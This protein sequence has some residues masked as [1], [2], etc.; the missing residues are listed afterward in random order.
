VVAEIQYCDL[1]IRGRPPPDD[2]I[3]LQALPQAYWTNEKNKLRDKENKLRDEKNKLL[4]KENVLQ[5]KSELLLKNYYITNWK[6]AEVHEITYKGNFGVFLFQLGVGFHVGAGK[7]LYALMPGAAQEEKIR[8]TNKAELEDILKFID[9]KSE[10]VEE[11]SQV[12]FVYP[13][14]ETPENSPVKTFV[15]PINEAVRNDVISTS[16]GSSQTG[17]AKTDR[18]TYQRRFAARLATRDET[19]RLCGGDKALQGAHIVDAEV[20]LTIDEMKALDL[21]H[22]YDLWNGILLCAVCH[23]QYDHWKLGID[24]DGFL[25]KKVRS[26]WVRE[27]TVNIFPHPSSEYKERREYPQPRLLKWKFNRFVAKRD[28]IIQRVS[29]GITSLFVSPTK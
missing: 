22:K 20:A 26:Q 16:S 1:Y 3:A 9:D 8:I 12:L 15:P 23:Q 29:D 24:E 2:D 17:S 13:E 27:A 4:D 11:A 25:W 6:T 21:G 5:G 19:C 7:R 14:D 28:N 10:F 18:S